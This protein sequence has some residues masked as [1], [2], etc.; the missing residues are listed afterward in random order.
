MSSMGGIDFAFV[1][2]PVGEEG[3]SDARALQG[4]PGGLPNSPTGPAIGPPG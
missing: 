2:A 1:A 4:D 3:L